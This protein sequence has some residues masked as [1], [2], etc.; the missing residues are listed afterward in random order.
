MDVMRER[1]FN[2]NSMHVTIPV[3]N[4]AIETM[5]LICRFICRFRLERDPEIEFLATLDVFH[6]QRASFNK[7]SGA[8]F[9][10]VEV[11]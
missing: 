2:L 11:M 1:D 4:D 7:G 5:S 8:D 10:F 9:V 6:W 3:R